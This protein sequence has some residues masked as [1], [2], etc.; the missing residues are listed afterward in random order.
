LLF[1]ALALVATGCNTVTCGPGT[2]QQQRPGGSNWCVPSAQPPNAT[3]CDDAD[4]GSQINVDGVCVSRTVCDPS[5]SMPVVDPNSGKVVCV[6]TGGGGGCSATQPDSTHISVTGNIW[7]LDGSPAGTKISAGGIDNTVNVTVGFF[8]PLSFLANPAE[9][10]IAFDNSN[11]VAKSCY[12]MNNI[13]LPSTTLGAVGTQDD[14]TLGALDPSRKYVITGVGVIV[15]AGNIYHRDVYL[16][17]KSEVQMWTTQAGGG[18][19]FVQKGVVLGQFF[20]N[21]ALKQTNIVYDSTTLVPVG[22][23]TLLDGAA[24]AAGARYFK[25]RMV[26]DQATLMTTATAGAALAP[27]PPGLTMYS[28]MGGTCPSGSC[29]WQVNPGASVAGVVFVQDFFN[30]NLDNTAMGCM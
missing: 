30:C 12:V 27:S 11:P 29:K 26:I 2:V 3:P 4:G 1:A 20:D 9:Q 10:P 14:T 28:G 15:N 23:I 25:T 19:D 8:D 21:K 5:T 13:A 18:T 24:Q 7:K 6:G 16:V 22:G 17:E